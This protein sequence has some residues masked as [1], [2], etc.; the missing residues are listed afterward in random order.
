MKL[1]IA[2]HTILTSK[3][4]PAYVDA[5]FVIKVIYHFNNVWCQQHVGL[6]EVYVTK[7]RHTIDTHK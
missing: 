5:A 2:E 6:H 1:V 7:A 4:L 3:T